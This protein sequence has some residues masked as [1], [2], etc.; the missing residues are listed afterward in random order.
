MKW[1]SRLWI[2]LF[3]PFYFFFCK[4]DDVLGQKKF[5][6]SV[7]KV[8]GNAWVVSTSDTTTPIELGMGLLEG[9]KIILGKNAVLKVYSLNGS[10]KSFIGPDTVLITQKRFAGSPTKV[11]IFQMI[12]EYLRDKTRSLAS[13][14]GAV[15]GQEKLFYLITPRNTNICSGPILFRWRRWK[16]DAAYRF[17]ILD[18]FDLNN[19]LFT[20]IV[21]DTIL[22]VFP[23]SLSLLR[24]KKYYWEI[25][26][27]A[28][29]GA[30][31]IFD[32]SW[33]RLFTY[34]EER[35]FLMESVRL[36]N[37]KGNFDFLPLLAFYDKTGA[38]YREFEL[39]EW[40]TALY[41]EEPIFQIL[42]NSLFITMGLREKA[43][44]NF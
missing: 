3:I 42:R 21:Q 15:R 7:V 44:T 25:K 27:L 6:A 38:Y 12:L 14:R 13:V 10:L 31:P 9:E 34:H 39:L 18:S 28:P 2:F 43:N 11:K 24:G 37:A 26:V 30:D 40:L 8:E 41:P 20:T 35:N 5:L 22:Y 29:E 4:W 33:F 23:D 1:E 32:R 19:P 17:S 36:K 16:T